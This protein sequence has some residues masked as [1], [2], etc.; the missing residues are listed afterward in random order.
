M[1]FHPEKEKY[2]IDA[3]EK[4]NSSNALGD[5]MEA[6][7]RLT[8]DNPEDIGRNP[9][10]LAK[11][12][13][14]GL[15]PVAKHHYDE[16]RQ[17]TAEM[18]RKVDAIYDMCLKM[19]TLCQFGKMLGIEDKAQ[20]SARAQFILEKQLNEF[21]YNL[22]IDNVSA[23]ESCKITNIKDKADDILEYIINT[24]DG[25]VQEIK[26]E[27]GQVRVVSVENT[28]RQPKVEN[29]DSRIEKLNIPI[30]EAIDDDAAIIDFSD[31]DASDILSLV[32]QGGSSGEDD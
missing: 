2:I 13:S 1:S 25:I 23:F 19:L 15:T 17:A 18:K 27:Q 16:C 28:D 3:L 6:L 12:K 31:T 11:V 10:F 4:L 24:Y 14:F 21:M 32:A 7:V 9:E 29:K 22:G 30:K 26:A 8:M 5:Y 20:N